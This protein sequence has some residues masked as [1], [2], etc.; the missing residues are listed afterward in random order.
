[1]KQVSVLKQLKYL[2]LILFFLTVSGAHAQ[3]NAIL[4]SFSGIENSG[5][6]YLTWVISAG[7]TCNG[8]KIYRSVNQLPFEKIGEIPGI[9]GNSSSSQQYTFIDLHP[10][11]NATNHYLLELGGD[12]TSQVVSVNVIDL[13]DQGNQVRPNPVITDAKIFFNNKNKIPHYLNVFTMTGSFVSMQTTSSDYFNFRAPETGNNLY[14]F[15]IEDGNQ[16]LK[17]SGKLVILR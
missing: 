8:I 4:E 14:F 12:E 6:C 1:M 17:T 5:K 16:K 7:N 2:L 10:A 13:S 3:Q 11:I 15:T 9:C